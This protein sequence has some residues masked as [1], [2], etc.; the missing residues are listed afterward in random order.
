MAGV[1]RFAGQAQRLDELLATQSARLGDGAAADQFGEQRTASDGG[2]ATF[3]AKAAL[4]D[5]AIGNFQ[6]E[7]HNIAASRVLHLHRDIGR[8]QFADVA[9][10]LKMI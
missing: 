10:M 8:G 7:L 4:H 6:R 9:R 1:L 3:R 5:Q 2:D